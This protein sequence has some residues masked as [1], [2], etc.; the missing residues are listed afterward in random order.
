MT[1]TKPPVVAWI[2]WAVALV[3]STGL[4]AFAFAPTYA[5]VRSGPRG[6]IRDTESFISENGNSVLVLLAVPLV[7]TLLVGLALLLN[8]RRGALGAAWFLTVLLAVGNALALLTIGIVVVP[9]TAAL[10]TACALWGR[11]EP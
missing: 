10:I 2:A 6:T 8:R 4:L 1:T 11:P 3:W 9:A 5:R 7:I